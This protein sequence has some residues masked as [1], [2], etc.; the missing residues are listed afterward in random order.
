[1]RQGIAPGG[2]SSSDEDEQ[3]ALLISR[4]RKEVVIDK[5]DSL[6]SDIFSSAMLM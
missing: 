3:E 4:K 6:E 5:R 2:A 1:M